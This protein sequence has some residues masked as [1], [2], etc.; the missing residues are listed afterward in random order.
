MHGPA[1][2]RGVVGFLE[3][4]LALW[5]QRQKI[6]LVRADSGFC[7]DALLSFL[8][9]RSLPYIVVARMTRWVKREAERIVQWQD[10][11]ANYAVGEFQLKLHGWA[12]DSVRAGLVWAGTRSMCQVIH[13]VSLPPIVTMPQSWYGAT[14]IGVR[15][16][17]TE[18]PN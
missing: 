11:D 6:R 1:T 2:S 9:Q 10:L 14:T 15:T 16:W 3:E 13:S 18:S 12:S 4:A 7:D 5:G 17:K 8:E